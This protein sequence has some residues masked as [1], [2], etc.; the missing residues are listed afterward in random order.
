VWRIFA[1]VLAET[2]TL[3]LVEFMH[4]CIII[5]GATVLFF[6]YKYF[7]VLLSNGKRTPFLTYTPLAG[8]LCILTFVHIFGMSYI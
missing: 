7:Y 4:E 5:F 2:T 3:I 1:H 6:A 8:V